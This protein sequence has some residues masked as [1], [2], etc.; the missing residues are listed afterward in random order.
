MFKLV[1]EIRSKKGELHFKR[2]QIWSTRWFNIYLHYINKADDDKDFHDHPWSFWSIILKGNYIEHIG[3]KGIPEQQYYKSIF[4]WRWHCAYRKKDIPHRIFY[5]IGNKPVWSLVITGP[6]GRKWGYITEEG[7]KDH[8][9][10][11]QD[12]RNQ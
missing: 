9:K 1:K 8:E 5:I 3:I 12:K 10:Y 4:R 11:R 6:G 7:W 2:W